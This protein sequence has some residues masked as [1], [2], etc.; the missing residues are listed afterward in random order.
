MKI[1]RN[2][3]VYYIIQHR[4]VTD[5]K[6]SSSQ[7]SVLPHSEHRTQ[8]TSG[9]NPNLF[10]GVGEIFPSRRGQTGRN[11]RPEGSSLPPASTE[12]LKHWGGEKTLPPGSTP[13]QWT[14]AWTGQQWQSWETCGHGGYS[15]PRTATCS[16][17]TRKLAFHFCCPKICMKN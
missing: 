14:L 2:S 5:F 6:K 7:T 3:T 13:L 8:W 16:C 11:E 15:E 10:W 1:M 12:R 9:V 4:T 17:W